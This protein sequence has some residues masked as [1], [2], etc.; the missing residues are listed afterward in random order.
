MARKQMHTKTRSRHEA[1][2]RYHNQGLPNAQVAAILQCSIRTVCRWKRAVQHA[3]GEVKPPAKARRTRQR[4]YGTAVFELA[5]RLKQ[6]LPQRS[7]AAIARLMQKE[8]PGQSPSES[9]IRKFLAGKG[10]SFKKVANRHGY[11]KFQ[12]DKPNDLWQVDIAGVQSVGHLGKLY[13][14]AILDDHS[15][16]VVAARYFTEQTGASVLK[17]VRDAVMAHGRPN[18][19]LAD[20]GAQFRGAMKEYESRYVN[21][22]T[23]LGV[24]AIFSRPRHPQSKGKLERWFGTV[25]GSFLLE[26]RAKVAATPAMALGD[27][28]ALFGEWLAWYNT[29]KSH[30]SLPRRQV[31]AKA[32]F[33]SPRVSRP[34]EGLVDWN[35]WINAY[36]QRRVTKYNT[37][38]FKGLPIAVPPGYAGCTVDLLEL[39]DRVEVYHHEIL[40]CTHRRSPAEYFPG[41]KHVFRTIAQNGTIQYKK[42]W[43]TIDYKLAGK[44]IEVI[45]ADG[46]KTVL[47]YLDKVL[48]KQISL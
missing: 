27:F 9:S 18:Q 28:N 6:E 41:R 8:F 29:Q 4:A 33:A 32:Y 43:I 39:E 31:P 48:V 13:L 38:S 26:A 24:K 7:A 12:R 45:E 37:A 30:R 10:F 17:V 22:L 44:K 2:L 5:V 1:F 36:F 25:A 15:R 19:V 21:L 23:F 14:V 42:R 34:L 46:G 35:Q 20:N 16:Y 3:G 47:I 40:V 11:V